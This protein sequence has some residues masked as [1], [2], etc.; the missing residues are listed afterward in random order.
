M[1]T[2]ATKVLDRRSAHCTKTQAHKFVRKALLGHVFLQG[3]H[4]TQAASDYA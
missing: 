1:S 4:L 2:Q 3:H